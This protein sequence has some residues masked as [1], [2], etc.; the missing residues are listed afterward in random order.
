MKN[1][2][3][4]KIKFASDGFKPMKVKLN[5]DEKDL[6]INGNFDTNTEDL[7]YDEIIYYDGGGVEGYGY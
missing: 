7:Y 2:M 3:T 4:F 5:K 6:S 1:D